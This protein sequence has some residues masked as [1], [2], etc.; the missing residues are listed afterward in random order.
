LQ[1]GKKN[2]EFHIEHPQKIAAMILHIL[3]GLHLRF[4]RGYD[5]H[6]TSEA[7]RIS[8]EHETLLFGE[9]ILHGIS[10]K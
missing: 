4:F 7:D 6:A 1:E 10:N 9:S 5:Q 3:Q 8:Y 2:N